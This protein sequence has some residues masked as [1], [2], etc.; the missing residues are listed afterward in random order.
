M[1][2]DYRDDDRSKHRRR[3]GSRERR[4]RSRDRDER[5]RRSR[6]RDDG[7]RRRSRSKTPDKKRPRKLS[8]E[9][10]Q[11]RDVPLY[12]RKRLMSISSTSSE[13]EKQFD[14][15]MEALRKEKSEKRKVEK[16][17]LK[18]KETAEEKRIRRLA[19]KIKKEEGRKLE[20]I[21]GGAVAYNNL[22]NPFNDTNLT[23][24]FVWN[25]KLEKEGLTS[26]NKKQ[27]EEI[28]AEKVRR[29][30]RETEELRRNREA[31]QAAKEDIEMMA[32]E[33]EKQ[34]YGDYTLIEYKFQI[35]QARERTKIRIK[36]NRAKPIDL[37]VRY[38][39]FGV[40]KE[41]ED[42]GDFEL[43][44]PLTYI[45]NLSID[46]FEDLLA[47][48]KTFKKI[49]TCKDD[50][51]WDDI[52]VICEG[53]L[54]KL[55]DIRKRKEMDEAVHSSVKNDVLNKFKVNIYSKIK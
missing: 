47:D 31:R 40:S 11:I 29:N 1:P 13:D 41:E 26:L 34:M 35:Q 16:Q 18:E 5:R 25:K 43:V 30:I 22:N 17:K 2:R 19:K 46:D 52:R 27:L 14:D 7:N 38:S 4:R 39:V 54:E 24:P 44:D 49:A 45:K 32:R 42:Y 53:E 33:R 6:E 37:L 23:E 36:E 10:R 21:S 8:T 48:I 3:S 20:S 9:Q 28:H 12:E 50:A 55:K 15:K 51:F